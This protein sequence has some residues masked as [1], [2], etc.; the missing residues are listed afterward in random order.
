MLRILLITLG[1]LATGTLLADSRTTPAPSSR[2][3][4]V[5]AASDLQFAIEEIAARFEVET[6]HRVQLTLGSS[7]NFARQIRQG[8]PFDVYLSADE[9]YVLDL[10]ARG[11]TRDEGTLYARGRIVL[12][13][14]HNSALVADP[15]L[16]D[17]ERALADGRIRR[18]AIANP[19]HAPYG[20]RAEEALRHR[21][22]WDGLHA[23]LVFGENV[24]QAARFAASG[25]A[26]GGI[27][28]W[29]L[30]L[31]PAVAAQGSH[32]LIPE[33]W[34]R[35]LLQRMV[36]L[37]RASEAGEVFYDYMQ[38]EPARQVLRRYGFLLPGETLPM[39]GTAVEY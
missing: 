30:A 2:T 31:A 20:Q 12:F 26:Q 27:I 39:T 25:N 4:L 24:S 22:L 33:D 35:P 36:L 17:L 11:L 6:G 37:R 13:V 32:A 23:H 38:S 7:G 28:A 14:P 3:A 34:H 8:A 16:D 18:F 21:G 5:A 29:S 19:D 1:L 10:S 15:G 9:A